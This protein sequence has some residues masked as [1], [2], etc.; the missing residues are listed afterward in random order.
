MNL[1]ANMALCT[2]AMSLT[3]GRHRFGVMAIPTS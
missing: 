1:T 3:V 2:L